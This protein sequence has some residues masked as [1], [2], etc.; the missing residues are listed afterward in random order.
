MALAWV[1]S[2]LSPRWHCNWSTFR[3][4]DHGS[5]CNGC[6]GHLPTVPS[7]EFQLLIGL[8]FDISFCSTRNSQ[9]K[10]WA[11]HCWLSDL[12]AFSKQSQW[13]S[14]YVVHRFIKRIY[15]TSETLICEFS[16]PGWYPG[17]PQSRN[18]TSL[19]LCSFLPGPKCTSTNI[20][21]ILYYNIVT[22]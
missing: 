22:N 4:S 11:V 13:K 7:L 1:E 17:I 9:G 6:R 8:D 14:G 16:I 2:Q 5:I 19:A 10:V 20:T 15:N 18:I 12:V 21:M 3:P